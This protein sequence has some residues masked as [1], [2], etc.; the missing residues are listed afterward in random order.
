MF[1]LSPRDAH[2]EMK[3]VIHKNIRQAKAADTISHAIM[4]IDKTLRGHL[5]VR[6][7]YTKSEVTITFDAGAACRPAGISSLILAK[8]VKT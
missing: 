1:R 6:D 4:E 5:F 8:P 7:P 2:V 3:V